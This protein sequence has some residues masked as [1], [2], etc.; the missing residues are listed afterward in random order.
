M[1]MN[2]SYRPILL[3]NSKSQARQN[4]LGKNLAGL[5]EREFFNRIGQD[6]PLV[7][8]LFAGVCHRTTACRAT[9]RKRRAAERER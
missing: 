2:V 3:K 5:M 4:S 8:V 7:T 1:H 6:R 9:R